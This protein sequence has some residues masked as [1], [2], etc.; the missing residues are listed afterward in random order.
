VRFAEPPFKTRYFAPANLRAAAES[1][2]YMRLITQ[3]VENKYTLRYSGGLVPDLV[4]AL[5][6]GHG[7]YVSPVTGVSEA[8][9]RRL[10]EL[11]PIALVV[12]CAGGRAVNPI[13]GEDILTR[14]LENCDE[15]AGLICGTAAEVDIAK[16]A[17]LGSRP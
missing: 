16:K 14:P 8:K 4:H 12:E 17:L 5:V 2:A 10:Y 1:E 6:K 3:Y 7:V 11:F 9:L 13:D 15:T